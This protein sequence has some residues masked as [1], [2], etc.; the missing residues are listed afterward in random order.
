[1]PLLLPRVHCRH[2]WYG[3][4]FWCARQEGRGASDREYRSAPWQHGGPSAGT[5]LS[6]QRWSTRI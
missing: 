3:H 5:A 1:M 4:R 6:I 2:T